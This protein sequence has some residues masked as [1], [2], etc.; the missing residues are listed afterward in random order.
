MFTYF[1]WNSSFN[2]TCICCFSYIY[3]KFIPGPAENR[4][5]DMLCTKVKKYFYLSFVQILLHIL[6]RAEFIFLY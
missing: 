6:F 2:K 1:I 5:G 4:T 3:D